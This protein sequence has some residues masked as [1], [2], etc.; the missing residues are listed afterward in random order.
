MTTV[1]LVIAGFVACV[2]LGFL[3]AK[4]IRVG[5]KLDIV[6]IPNSDQGR[7][8]VAD[9]LRE[10]K[11]EIDSLATPGAVDSANS[12]LRARRNTQGGGP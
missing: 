5:K 11:H 7:R 8:V 9:I 6:E 1:L 10:R 2:G 3:L 12:I 4:L